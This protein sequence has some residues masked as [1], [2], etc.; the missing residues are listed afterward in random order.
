MNA[1]L[2]LVLKA[3]FD[4]KNSTY[5]N[6]H[7]RVTTRWRLNMLHLSDIAASPL[8]AIS[9]PGSTPCTRHNP[10]NTE[11]CRI[12]KLFTTHVQHFAILWSSWPRQ[13]CTKPAMRR[14]GCY[15]HTDIGHELLIYSY[16]HRSTQ[17]KRRTAVG[18]PNPGHWG[19]QARA[20]PCGRDGPRTSRYTVDADIRG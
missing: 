15:R 16:M 20:I 3:H 11:W 9:L 1:W 4:L 14:G 7:A 10:P 6:T 8:K 2:H 5:R 12:K 18:W 13:R 17:T 19:R